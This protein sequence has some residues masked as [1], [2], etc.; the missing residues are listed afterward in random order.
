MD[1]QAS[2]SN[3]ILKTPKHIN[4]LS[5]NKDNLKTSKIKNYDQPL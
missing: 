5:Q 1:W 2:A 3:W 4:Q